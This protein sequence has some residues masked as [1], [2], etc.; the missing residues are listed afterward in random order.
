MRSS[1][2]GK[3]TIPFTGDG[4]PFFLLL[5]ARM[6]LA[7]AMAISLFFNSLFLLLATD[8]II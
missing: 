1:S 7:Q 5:M 2:K 8:V 4:I 6:C 3:E